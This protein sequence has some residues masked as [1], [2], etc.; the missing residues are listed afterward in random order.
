MLPMKLEERLEQ[1]KEQVQSDDFLKSKGL[2]NEVPLWI[3]DYPPDKEL[4]IRDT[5]L[6]IN[7]SLE[8]RSITF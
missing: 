1:L 7:S 8:K 6:K 5:I 3:F 4:L 2:G